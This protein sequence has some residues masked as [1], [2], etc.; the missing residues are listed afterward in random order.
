MGKNV[1]YIHNAA[2]HGL[3]QQAYADSNQGFVSEM[4]G[5][6]PISMKNLSSNQWFVLP[7]LAI[8]ALIIL[9]IVLGMGGGR[10]GRGGGKTVI[11]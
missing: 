9:K 10:G 4:L 11:L 6:E 1:R 5:G 3:Q 8:G 7:A 2:V